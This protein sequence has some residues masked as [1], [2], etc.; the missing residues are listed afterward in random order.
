MMRAPRVLEFTL[1]PAQCLLSQGFNVIDVTITQQ[2]HKSSTEQLCRSTV[3]VPFQSMPIAFIDTKQTMQCLAVD[4]RL[5]RP[6][7]PV[8]PHG[9]PTTAA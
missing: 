7:A 2:L 9:V 3:S 6:F 1:D 8:G 5:I 4:Q